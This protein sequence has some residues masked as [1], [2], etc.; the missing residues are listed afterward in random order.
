MAIQDLKAQI[1]RLPEQRLLV[2][3]EF[4]HIA[5]F[6]HHADRSVVSSVGT[7]ERSNAAG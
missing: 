5:G 3:A 7:G 1:V 4:D 2:G 6:Y